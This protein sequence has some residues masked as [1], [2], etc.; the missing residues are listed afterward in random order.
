M[1]RVAR[2]AA[3]FSAQVGGTRLVGLK[4]RGKP[5]EGCFGKIVPEASCCSVN[6]SS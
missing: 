5:Q 1:T 4:G 2:K 3:W 6:R